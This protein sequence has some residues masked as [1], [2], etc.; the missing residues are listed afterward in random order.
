MP[1][2]KPRGMPK[3]WGFLYGLIIIDVSILYMNVTN[4]YNLIKKAADLL[5]Q[6][7]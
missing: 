5:C 6:Q 2:Q 4:I 1:A 7:L 3:Y